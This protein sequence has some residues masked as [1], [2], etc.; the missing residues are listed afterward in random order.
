MRQPPFSVRQV[1]VLVLAML[2][3][4][5]LVTVAGAQSQEPKPDLPPTPVAGTDLPTGDSAPSGVSGSSWEGP[6]FGVRVSWDPAVWSVEGEFIDTGYDGLQI[7]TP[8]STVYL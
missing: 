3:S 4:F 2:I 5:G 7:G 6:N 8:V 1:P